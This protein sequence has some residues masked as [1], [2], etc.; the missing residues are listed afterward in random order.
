MAGRG[1]T[2]CFEDLQQL[3]LKLHRDRRLEISLSPYQIAGNKIN[4]IAG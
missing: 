4:S 3:T 1:Y 2:L